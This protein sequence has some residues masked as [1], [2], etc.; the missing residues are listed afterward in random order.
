MQRND[1]TRARA[2]DDTGAAAPTPLFLAYLAS[3]GLAAAGSFF[4]GFGTDAV[5]DFLLL[6]AIVSGSVLVLF[7]V[8]MIWS[9]RAGHRVA[10][11]AAA[12]PGALVL[13]GAR[14]RGSGGPCAP[15]APTCPSCRSASRCSPTTRASRC[16]AD[17]PSIPCGSD[18]HRGSA[19]PTSGS[20]V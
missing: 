6:A 10:A 2:A 5:I 18:A 9:A 13:R 20:R 3:L 12:R 16:G 7:A 4:G 1:G 17:R 14:A 15:C 19:S 8:L 11:L